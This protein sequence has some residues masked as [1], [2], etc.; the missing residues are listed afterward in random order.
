VSM[1]RFESV[2]AGYGRSQVL[3]DV[4]AA[5]ESGRITAIIGPN[6]SGKSTLLRCALAPYGEVRLLGGRVLLGDRDMAGLTVRERVSRLAY[7][8]Q[9]PAISG[10]FTVRAIVSMGRY[11]LPASDQ[12]IDASLEVTGMSD[13]QHR[14]FGE[15]SAGQQQRT[16]MARALAQL[17]DRSSGAV[18]L[19]DEPTSAMDIR[20]VIETLDLLRARADDGLAIGIVLHD[21]AMVRRWAD[22]AIMLQGGRV[23]ATGSVDSVLKAGRVVSV[24]GVRFVDEAFSHAEIADDPIPCGRRIGHKDLE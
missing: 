18:L 12:A 10:P 7:L 16:A 13:L 15:L 23:A 24:F 5:L 11:A 17:H 1:L 9:R 6:G 2:A 20:H 22:G 8:P 14:V 4:T 3:A 21:L 19:A